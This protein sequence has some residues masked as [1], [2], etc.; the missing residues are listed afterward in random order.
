MLCLHWSTGGNRTQRKSTRFHGQ[1]RIKFVSYLH[2]TV[3]FTL[4]NDQKPIFTYVFDE[5]TTLQLHD[6]FVLPEQSHSETLTEC[7]QALLN[8]ATGHLH[9]RCSS[10]SQLAVKRVKQRNRKLMTSK[11][12]WIGLPARKKPGGVLT[13]HMGPHRDLYSHPEFHGVHKVA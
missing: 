3:G 11:E 5:E 8:E 2:S 1:L 9:V 12:W 4:T 10:G 6:T 13:F 7:G